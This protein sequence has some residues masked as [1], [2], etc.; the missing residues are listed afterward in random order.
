MEWNDPPHIS[1]YQ[2]HEKKWNFQKIAPKIVAPNLCDPRSLR[3]DVHPLRLLPRTSAGL[4]PV[5]PLILRFPDLIAAARVMTL[6]LE[7][8]IVNE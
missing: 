6:V 3:S 4:V 1:S 2:L 8:G 7:L 5:V